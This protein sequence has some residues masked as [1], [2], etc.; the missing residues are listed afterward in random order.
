MMIEEGRPD[1]TPTNGL[2]RVLLPVPCGDPAT[3]FYHLCGP[4]RGIAEENLRSTAENV[5][6]Q[7]TMP[8][9]TKKSSSSYA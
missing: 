8:L 3:L 4:G 2:V 5:R 6:R 1:A 7:G 9:L